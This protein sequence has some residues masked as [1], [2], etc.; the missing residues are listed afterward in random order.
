MDI[1]TI[2]LA[3]WSR[4]DFEG[5][6]PGPEDEHEDESVDLAELT[7]ECNPNMKSSAH[8][9]APRSPD[10][11]SQAKPSNQTKSFFVPECLLGVGVGEGGVLYTKWR[12]L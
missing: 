9:V 10:K 12:H 4:G 8:T 1:E 2:K 11:R 5:W 7:L 3:K 6:L